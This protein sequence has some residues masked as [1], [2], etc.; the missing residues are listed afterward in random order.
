M[1]NEDLLK[2]H[3]EQMREKQIFK[4]NEREQKM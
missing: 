2:D 4:E 3:L 1:S